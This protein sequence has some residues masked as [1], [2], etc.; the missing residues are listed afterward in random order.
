MTL[1]LVLDQMLLQELQSDVSAL[2]LVSLFGS[3]VVRLFFVYEMK[4]LNYFLLKQVIHKRP[5]QVYL[6]LCQT[7]K[8]KLFCENVF[9]K[10]LYYRRLTGF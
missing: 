9:V 2:I 10:K 3:L 7:S 1:L 6:G 8:M 4:K 5:T